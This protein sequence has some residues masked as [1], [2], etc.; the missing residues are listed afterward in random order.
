[1]R[2]LTITRRKSF[3][4]CLA[5][6]QV[7]IRDEAASELIIDGV[8]CRKIGEIKNGETKSFQVEDGELQIY[9]IVDK[10]SKD[11]CNATVT[12]PAGQEDVAYSGAHKF[13]LGSN[14]FCFDGVELSDV[15]QAKQKKNGRTGVIIMIAAIIIGII[16]GTISSGALHSLLR[17]GSKTFTD[18]DFQITLTKEFKFAEYDDFFAAYE[19]NS[20]VVFVV[21]EEKDLFEDITLD[22]YGVLAQEANGRTGIPIHQQDNLIYFTYTASPEGDE[23]YY[24]CVV[25]CEGADTFWIVN[26]ATPVSNQEKYA[27]TFLDWAKTI[28]IN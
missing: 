3:V 2:N 22:E 24:Y 28:Q 10:L 17:S 27:E 15:Q 5:K 21:R 11:Y 13:S 1:M 19:S 12:V 18:E 25:C 6:D 20:A 26:F 16:I 9:L 14:P 7:Y 8:P 23:V 4:G